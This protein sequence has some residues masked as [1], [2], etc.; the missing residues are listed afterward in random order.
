M[1]CCWETS[2]SCQPAL[3]HPSIGDVRKALGMNQ[4]HVIAFYCWGVVV[5]TVVIGTTT[6][7]LM[8]WTVSCLNLFLWMCLCYVKHDFVTNNW[9]TLM[10]VEPNPPT[11]HNYYN[12][13][14][15]LCVSLK[16]TLN[17]LVDPRQYALIVILAKTASILVM[18]I[19]FSQHSFLSFLQ[20]IGRTPSLCTQCCLTVRQKYSSSIFGQHNHYTIVCTYVD[21]NYWKQ[22]AAVQNAHSVF[23]VHQQSHQ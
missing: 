4:H 5:G 6:L 2:T 19:H 16:V 9:R 8:F 15:L 11:H 18:K 13:C 22:S 17:W 1:I 7:V 14:T 23:T 3:A 10:S 20:V 21:N 12:C